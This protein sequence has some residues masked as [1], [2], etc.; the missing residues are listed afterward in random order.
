[1]RTGSAIYQT[2]YGHLTIPCLEVKEG[3]LIQ[4]PFKAD[5]MKPLNYPI[6]TLNFVPLL[7][8]PGMIMKFL[9]NP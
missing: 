2:F 4:T 5:C 8:L 9:E 3:R 6:L 1:M 7:I